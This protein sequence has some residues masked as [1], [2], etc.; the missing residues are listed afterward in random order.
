MDTHNWAVVGLRL[1][2][3]CQIG[4]EAEWIEGELTAD[5]VA[6]DTIIP[7]AMA[8]GIPI[9]PSPQSLCGMEY[10]VSSVESIPNPGERRC[11]IWT[12]GASA[13]KRIIMRVA[14]VY[15]GLLSLSRC[16]D[17][18]SENRFW[19]VA[20]AP[21]DETMGEL[22][23]LSRKGRLYVWKC[24][25]KGR[26]FCLAGM[27]NAKPASVSPSIRPISKVNKGD[28]AATPRRTQ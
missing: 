24:W 28:A 16:A 23:P 10:E 27:T 14:D 2:S 21:I 11:L 9:M 18:A 12:E 17:M 5:S 19:R 26:A 8:K 22:I 4:Q 1:P 25:I 15:Q 6:C 3:L 13:A 7:R 20:G